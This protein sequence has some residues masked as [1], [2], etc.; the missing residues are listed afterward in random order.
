MD[1]RSEFSEFGNVTYL[2]V[3]AQGPLPHASAQALRKAIEWK[4]LPQRM[5]SDVYFGLPDRVRGLLARIINAKPSEIA[6]TT[7]AT[8]GLAAIA[9][10][11]EW[12]PEDEVLVAE[13]E[14]RP[15]FPD[16]IEDNEARRCPVAA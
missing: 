1:Y 2:D 9:W 13:R 6:V 15:L 11:I 7:G 12:K 10:G 14:F 3:A 16:R 4:E 8:T 5:P